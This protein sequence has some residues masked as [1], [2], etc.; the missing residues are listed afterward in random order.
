MDATGP[1]TSALTDPFRA[2]RGRRAARNQSKVIDL[3][4][5]HD[6]VAITTGRVTVRGKHL[7]CGPTPYRVHGITYGTF[8]PRSD[9]A[10]FP[11]PA[12]VRSDLVQMRSLGLDTVRTYEAPPVDLLDTAREL[13]MRVLVG[14]HHHDWQTERHTGSDARRRILSAA[15]RAVDE[16]LALV[17]D[18]PEVLGVAVGNELPVDLVRMHG[19][20]RVEATLVRMVDRLHEGDPGLLTTYVNFP[21][22]EFLEVPNTDL[23]AFNVFL[24]DGAAFAQYAQHLQLVSRDKPLLVTELGHAAEVHGEQ[25][26]AA[27]LAAQLRHIDELGIAGG[28]VFSWTDE[29]AV[30]GHAVRGWGFGVTTEDRHPKPAS[31]VVSAWGQRNHPEDLRASWPRVSVIVCAYNEEATIGACVDSVLASTYPDLELIVCDDGSTDATAQIVDA[32][33][34]RLLRLDHGGLSRARN[35]GLHAST[36]EVVAYLDADAACHPDWPYHLALSLEGGAAATGG[37]NLPYPGAELT[38]R[39]IGHVPG[40]ASEV[41]FESGRAEHVPGCNMAFDRARLLEIGGFDDRYVAAGDDVDVCWKL[42]ESGYE[43]AFSPAAQVDHHRRATIR[44]F[45]RQQRGYGRAERMLAGPHRHRMNRIGQARWRGYVYGP[46]AFLPGILRSTVYTGWAGTAAFQP[47]ISHRAE[48]FGGLVNATLPMVVAAGALATLA[49]LAARAALIVTAASVAWVVGVSIAAACS[50]RVPHTEP[51]PRRLRAIVGLLT[52]LQPLARAWGRIWGSPLDAHPEPPRPWAGDRISWLEAL[53]HG[54][55]ARGH[56]VHHPRSGDFWDLR[57]SGHGPIAI[58]LTTAV[59]WSWE[60]R[61][62]IRHC[63]HLGW[64][65][66]ALAIMVIGALAGP[67]AF[68]LTLVVVLVHASLSTVRL[69]SVVRSVLATTTATAR[70]DPDPASTP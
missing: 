24:E 38:E 11:G 52:V 5:P 55:K 16:A 34:A 35:A 69:R 21:T 61:W 42:L 33:G 17:A 56:A 30:S 19:R 40:Q 22:T 23:V 59:A 12:Q 15:D 68:S 64:S 25:A 28:F 47:A 41:L 20:A 54:F 29:W 1:Q 57:I 8:A 50:A 10:G 45:L 36:G 58:R 39:A 51:T 48:A 43:I 63:L 13:G 53:E 60:P 66:A 14:L 2:P 32:R 49:G 27:L 7:W 4:A 37:P 9:G 3:T 26:Q 6:P 67:V 65:L 31:R 18:R 62:V 70:S 44:A 46:G